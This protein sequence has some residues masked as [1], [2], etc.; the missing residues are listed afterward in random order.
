MPLFVSIDRPVAYISAHAS[1]MDYAEEIPFRNYFESDAM[2]SMLNEIRVAGVIY[3]LRQSCATDFIPVIGDFLVEGFSP[4]FVGHG[5][6]PAEARENWALLV[7]ATFQELQYKRPFE[8]TQEDIK[9]WSVLSSK[10]DITVFR[11]N[12]PIHV[13][14]FGKIVSRRLSYPNKLQWENG[15]KEDITLDQVDSPDFVTYKEGQ[16]I[17]AVV[18]RDPLTFKLIRIIDVRRRSSVSRLKVNEE[19]QLLNDIGSA[20]N[21][22]ADGW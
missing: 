8:M 22:P 4:T 20:E 10:I 16:P 12:V 21:L 9:R 13:R 17:E 1:A 5:T 15:I 11:N 7:H 2:R 3:P 6:T 14:E 19:A 18:A